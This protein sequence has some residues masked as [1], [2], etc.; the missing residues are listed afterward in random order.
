MHNTDLVVYTDHRDMVA[1]DLKRVDLHFDYST[2]CPDLLGQIKVGYNWLWSWATRWDIQINPTQLV[3]FNAEPR[4]MQPR[5]MNHF[6]YKLIQGRTPLTT[7]W[8]WNENES[9]YVLPPDEVALIW[10]AM[11]RQ[12]GVNETETRILQLACKGSFPFHTANAMCRWLP[13]R[14]LEPDNFVWEVSWWFLE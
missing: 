5:S 1:V 3:R 14:P 2:T 11:T 10:R 4:H 13:F 7:M 8:T 12:S 9:P 6:H